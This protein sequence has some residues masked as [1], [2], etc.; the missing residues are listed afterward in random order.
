MAR[1]KG[2]LMVILGSSL[3]GISGNVAHFL[4]Q[5]KGFS[6]GWMVTTRMLVSGVLLLLFAFFGSARDQVLGVW[7]DARDRIRI[8]LFGLLGMLGVQYTFFLAIE[9]GNAAT[10][11]LLQYLGPM[12]ITVYLAARLGRLPSLRES[13]AV[14]LAIL[15]T[16]LLVTNGSLSELSIS[17][18]AVF[19]GLLSGVALA[20]YTLYPAGLLN[21]FASPIIIGW[22]MIIGG[23]GIGLFHHPW[24]ISG[25]EWSWSTFAYVAFV[26]VFGT[27]VAFYLYLDSLRY[28]QPAETSLLASMEPL[29]AVL[30][31]V[32]WLQVPFRLFEIIGSL[33]I[34]TTV[35]LLS[36][37]QS[38]DPLPSEKRHK[39]T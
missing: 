39:S 15:G 12:F 25:Q 9:T 13:G 36:L 2:F 22:G 33:C 32:L 8:L 35:T 16:F 3:W 34:I 7:R 4:F 30:T 31:A 19:W 1:W 14:L 23:L 24:D 27:L 10:A 28:I 18:V 26:I 5:E 37:P 6:A 38:S 17:G 20:F 29:V 21:R 11:T